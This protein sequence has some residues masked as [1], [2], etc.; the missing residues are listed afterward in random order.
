MPGWREK[1]WQSA[2]GSYGIEHRARLNPDLFAAI[3]IHGDGTEPP[4]HRLNYPIL[5]V[6][7]HGPH[8]P[9]S[10]HDTATRECSVKK[11][12]HIDFCQAACPGFKGIELITGVGR[13]HE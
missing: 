11:S 9:I 4:G 13:R 10:P 7:A 3:E 5:Q 8:Q 6:F 2:G 12:P 1:A